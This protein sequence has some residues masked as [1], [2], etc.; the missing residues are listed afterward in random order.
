MAI[1]VAIWNRNVVVVVIATITW[2]INGAFFIQGKSPIFRQSETPFL[3][4]WASGIS[5]VSNNFR[6]IELFVLIA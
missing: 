1:S 4:G 3:S 2:A 5:Q 6:Y